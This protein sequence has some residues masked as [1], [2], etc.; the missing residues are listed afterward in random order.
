MSRFLLI[1]C[2]RKI[3]VNTKKKFCQQPLIVLLSLKVNKL[4]KNVIVVKKENKIKKLT[5]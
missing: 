2:C 4:C 3:H 1:V 5:L